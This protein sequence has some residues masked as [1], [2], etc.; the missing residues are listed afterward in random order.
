MEHIYT[1]T[2]QLP[3]A[4]VDNLT[5]SMWGVHVSAIFGVLS[6]NLR[7][8]FDG[9]DEEPAMLFKPC[10]SRPTSSVTGLFHSYFRWSKT[11]WGGSGPKCRGVWTLT[12][13]TAPRSNDAGELVLPWFFAC[14]LI[15]LAILRT[16]ST[17]PTRSSFAFSKSSAMQW[18]SHVISLTNTVQ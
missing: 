16:V 8:D 10:L 7:A 6:L 14:E 12:R 4:K 5:H 2:L 13:T 18:Q 11:T 17:S 3:I 9:T 15:W 1:C